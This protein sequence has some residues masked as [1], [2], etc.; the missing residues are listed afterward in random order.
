MTSVHS[1][2]LTQGHT[3]AQTDIRTGNCGRTSASYHTLGPDYT[4]AQGR[5]LMLD[6]T[7]AKGHTND[8]DLVRM[9][10][11]AG[12]HHF[13]AQDHTVATGCNLTTTQSHNSGQV[14]TLTQAKIAA[15][16]VVRTSAR[17]N[18][19]AA[20]AADHTFALARK[21]ASTN[22]HTTSLVHSC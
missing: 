15:H 20:N 10:A 16:V 8:S 14:H 17:A 13:D 12:I 9:L 11:L 21:R 4:V 6:Y 1:H 22:N 18:I 2:N 3:Q 19:A 7:V 5:T